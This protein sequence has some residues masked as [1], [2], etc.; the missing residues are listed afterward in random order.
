MS[1]LLPYI[2]QKQPTSDDRSFNYGDGCFTTMLKMGEFISLKSFHAR[3]LFNDSQRLGIFNSTLNIALTDFLLLIEHIEAHNIGAI[4]TNELSRKVVKISISRGEGGRGYTP[5][6]NSNPIIFVSTHTLAT[7][8]PEGLNIAL[9]TSVELAEQPLLAGIKHKNRLE[10]VLAKLELK[11]Y[12]KIDDLL[13]SSTSGCLIECTASNIFLKRG[14]TWYTPDL[15]TCG[16]AGVMREFVLHY[17]ETSGIAYQIARVTQDDLSSVS[18]AFCCN[19]LLGISPIKT[20]ELGKDSL[21]LNYAATIVM[22]GI[23]NNALQQEV[24]NYR[25]EQK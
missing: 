3:R 14:D 19:A 1:K 16:V 8:V 15:S 13:L 7:P 11:D 21:T 5:D 25:S 24:I 20:I 2:S 12:P 10:Q 18:E 4:P 17:M 6:K 9:C 22:K 23:I